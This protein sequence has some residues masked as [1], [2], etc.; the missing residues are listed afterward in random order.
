MISVIAESPA[1]LETLSSCVCSQSAARTVEISGHS[2]PLCARCAGVLLG[3]GMGMTWSLTRRLADPRG[4]TM[5]GLGLV[6]AIGVLAPFVEHSES[7]RQVL[8][9]LTNIE[10]TPN[11][12]FGTASVATFSAGLIVAPVFR[13][14]VL[15]RSGDAAHDSSSMKLSTL[16]VAVATSAALYVAEALGV[17]FVSPLA[18]ASLI[19]VGLASLATIARVVS[20]GRIA[21][22]PLA[23]IASVALLGLLY[24]GHLYRHL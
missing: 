24:V 3:A 15:S 5:I 9:F 13:R 11:L 4:T 18:I 14:R 1:V 16:A 19:G 23:V 20:G 12:R 2:M 7:F 10:W 22:L 21:T 8:P 6:I 17:D